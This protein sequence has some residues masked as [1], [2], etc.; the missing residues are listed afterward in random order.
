MIGWK[1]VTKTPN[2][3]LEGNYKRPGVKEHIRLEAHERCVYCGIHENFIGGINAFHKDHYKPKV[4]FEELKHTLGNL[5]YS[6][7][8]CNT[9]KSDEWPNEPR[10]DHSIAAFPDPAKVDYNDLFII[11]WKT[12]IIKGAFTAA[13]YVENQLYL[14]RPQLTLT[15]QEYNL[16]QRSNIISAETLP[17]VSQ[18]LALRTKESLQLVFEYQA[19][20]QQLQAV[21][22]AG[23]T[24]PRY[25][26]ED[27]EK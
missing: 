11:N 19:A 5:Y 12:G 18:L 22:M 20:W 15:R 1:I 24:I 8:I 17:L 7:P 10:S 21:I 25:E 23:Q 13:L 2:A 27:V 6:C 9:F 26:K 16:L 4:R 14:N 3:A